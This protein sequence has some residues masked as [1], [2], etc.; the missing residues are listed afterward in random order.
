MTSLMEANQ[1]TSS[2]EKNIKVHKEVLGDPQWMW[3]PGIVAAQ[4][5]SPQEELRS[6]AEAHRP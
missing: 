1:T 4:L 5:Q 2:Q 3:E 6:G